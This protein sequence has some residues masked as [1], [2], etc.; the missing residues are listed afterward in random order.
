[1]RIVKTPSED[2]LR[3]AFLYL[4]AVIVLR[5]FMVVVDL[6]L[7]MMVVVWLLW[8]ELVLFLKL[9][10]FNVICYIILRFLFFLKQRGTFLVLRDF[11]F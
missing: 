6:R 8:C 5:L 9:E 2:N 4:I 3:M 10:I 11:Q 1:M 7:F